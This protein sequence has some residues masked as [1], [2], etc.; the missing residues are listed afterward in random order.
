MRA[1]LLVHYGPVDLGATGPIAARLV[2][3]D[4]PVSPAAIAAAYRSSF[5]PDEAVLVLTELRYAHA[6][7]A[8]AAALAVTHKGQGLPSR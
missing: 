2:F 7:A 3:G 5:A 1:D 4:E 6:A 8:L